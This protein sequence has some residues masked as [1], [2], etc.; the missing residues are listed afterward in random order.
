MPSDQGKPATVLR[1]APELPATPFCSLSCP[2]AAWSWNP[3][4][5]AYSPFDLRDLRVCNHQPVTMTAI[6]MRIMRVMMIPRACN[7]A[8]LL[9]GEVGSRSWIQFG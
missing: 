3:E 8:S 1:A 6:T 5:P 7:A 9:C 4:A 2:G